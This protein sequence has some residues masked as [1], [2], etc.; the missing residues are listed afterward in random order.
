MKSLVQR[1]GMKY[2]SHNHRWYATRSFSTETLSSLINY[3][4]INEPTHAFASRIH[5]YSRYASFINDEYDKL[6]LLEPSRRK[7]LRN[8]KELPRIGTN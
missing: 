1:S 4:S 2:N 5:V 7:S 6:R 8:H 3:H